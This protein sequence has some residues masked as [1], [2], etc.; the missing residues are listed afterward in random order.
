MSKNPKG[1]K[2]R[3]EAVREKRQKRQRQQR[4]YI[5]LGVVV[6]AIIISAMLIIPDLLPAGDVVLITPIPR[7]MVDGKAL[8][9]PN[10]PV[11]IEVFEDFQCPSCKSYS[12][13]VEPQVIETYVN[14]GQVY[15]IYRHFPFLDDGAPR[16]ESDQA[17][18]AS[19][20]AADQERFW[21]YHDMLFANW[22]GENQGAFTDKRL[23]AFAEA[24]ELD[25]QSFNDCFDSNVHKEEIDS[26]LQLGRD[27]GVT[28]TPSVL[29]NGTILTP[30]FIPSFGDVSEAVEQELANPES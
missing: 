13:Q 28:G 12:E 10:A 21:D 15:Y 1:T 25:M 3:R 16:N 14:S 19:M 30:G 29:V 26:E 20:C 27:S 5:F 23:V 8:G 24:L 6:V 9:D 4:L 22:D 11:T 17:A 18:N 7:T 2:T